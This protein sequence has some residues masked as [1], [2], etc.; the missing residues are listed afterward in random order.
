MPRAKLEEII[1]D[2]KIEDLS[3]FFRLKTQV[4]GNFRS[5]NEKLSQ[6]NDDFFSNFCR[7]GQIE[8]SITE[9]LIVAGAEVKRDLSERSGKKYQYEKAKKILKEL[10]VYSAGIFIFYD[11]SGNFRFSLVYPEAAGRRREWSS[12]RRFT[13]FVSK[14][15][16]NKT[17]LSR[18]GDGNFSSLV[19][20]K[21]AFSV[22]KVTK[23]FY[24]E[25][26]KLFESLLNELSKNHTFKIEASRNNISPENFAKKLLGQIV[27]L[28]FVQKKGWLG[29]SSGSKW[30]EGNKNFMGDLFREAMKKKAN[31]FNDYLEKLFYNA[32]NNPRRNS[33][34]P[35]FSKDF[36]CRIPF[37][38]GGLFEAEYDWEDSL[39]YLDN[40]IFKAIFGVFERYNFTIEEESPDDKEIAVDPEM[41]GKVFENLLPE[42][43]RKGKGTYY[44]PREIVYYMC[45]ESL[46]NYI[47]S[48]VDDEKYLLKVRKFV[49]GD[50]EI[51]KEELSRIFDETTAEKAADKVL[52]FDKNEARA[53]DKLLMEIKV[54]DPAC[55]S[56][57]FLVGMLNEIVR[58]R[59]FLDDWYLGRKTT[60]YEL[61]KETIQNCIYGV[62]IDPGAIEIA[63]LRLW[64]SL[65]VDYGIEDIE[66]LPNLD[67]RLMCGNSLLEEYEDVKF[68]NGEDGAQQASLLVDTDKQKQVAELKKKVKEYFDIHDDKEKQ[69][70]RKEINDIK[71]WLVRSALEKRKHDLA[72]QRKNEEA[73]ANMLDKKSRE[74]Y[75]ASWG[76]KFLA[77]AKIKEVL[78]DLHNPKAAK[79][80]F[81]WKLEFMDVFADKKGFD[82]MIA[83]PPYLSSK[84]IEETL[85]PIYEKTFYSPTAHYDI[86][87]IFIERALQLLKEGGNLCFI[88]SNKY[89]SQKYGF[90]IRELLLKKYLLRIINFN[91]K[92]FEATVDTAIT[93]VENCANQIGH[94]VKILDLYDTDLKN[95][96]SSLGQILIDDGRY[97]F[98]RQDF[99][100]ELPDS[101]FRLD[102]QQKDFD[103]Q[104]KIHNETVPLADIC[105]VIY[106]AVLHNAEK[107][108]K[109]DKF[110][111]QE[112]NKNLKSYIEG[113]YISRW[114]VN[115]EFY[116]KYTPDVHREP[117]YPE[118]FENRKLVGKRIIG[119]DGL[120]FLY[121]QNNLYTDNTVYI[122]IPYCFLPRNKYS[123]LNSVISDNRIK[124]S[125]E[126]SLLFLLSII[127]SSLFKW[128]FQKF[129]SFGLDIYPIH[130][131][132]LPIKTIG[133]DG[134]K[135][136]IDLVNKIIA[137][138]KTADYPDNSPKQIKVKEYEKQIDQMVCKLYGLTKEEIK[139]VENEE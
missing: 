74:R 77:E 106:G 69:A 51:N 32:L 8:F 12:F 118:L 123:Q 45:R 16:T 105:F 130:L 11:Q 124:Q 28:Y 56:G 70:K 93:I 121:D 117:R 126:Y 75:L 95:D 57:A 43:L 100:R 10:A 17:F 132:K 18:I 2:F 20:I 129:F 94:K 98:I 110:I 137:I 5:V 99:F 41:L 3:N 72:A 79:P 14:E 88:T 19:K 29:V 107:N 138:T 134:Q 62:D 82:V 63:K 35:S 59:K 83:N 102:V 55:G 30:G 85:K 86:Y 22:E 108:V 73:K 53:I 87:I 46:I 131:K 33:V 1:N 4:Q 104:K 125:Q 103:L 127:N 38:N 26:R 133:E 116:L 58:M 54:C 71:D 81:I 64:L 9:K 52:V 84:N 23:E 13:Y 76:D 6:Y 109:K 50:T 36:N 40:N 39:I 122:I 37:L 112:N 115:K 21:E 120:S 136:F 135:P 61:K 119:R 60:E 65:V 91:F 139:I 44:T 24:L 113:K 67:Y 68:Y 90:K 114:R 89:F 128:L 66:P 31:F 80:F 47:S 7:L 34:D 25:Y 111:Y 49:N 27:F 101:N 48:G 15:F 96:S 97:Q 42:N 78:D 92:I